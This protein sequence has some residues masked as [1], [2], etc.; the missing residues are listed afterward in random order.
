MVTMPYWQ[1]SETK[2]VKSYLRAIH[3]ISRLDLRLLHVARR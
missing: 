1:N 2:V 3:G